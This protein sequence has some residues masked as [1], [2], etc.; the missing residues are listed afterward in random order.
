M[1][2]SFNFENYRKALAK[3]L[4]DERKNVSPESTQDKLEEKKGL[5]KYKISELL[6]KA[7]KKMVLDEVLTKHKYTEK[8]EKN[9]LSL[10]IEEIDISNQI[11]EVIKLSIDLDRI[12]A[13]NGETYSSKK[14]TAEL[15]DEII[16]LVEEELKN[17][18]VESGNI[19]RLKTEFVN[20]I[21]GGALLDGN[22]I[23]TIID[24]WGRSMQYE[25]R[26]DKN[27]Y[28]IGERLLADTKYDLPF[29]PNQYITT[30]PDIP[31]NFDRQDM[32][33][34]QELWFSSPSSK[35]ESINNYF[36]KTNKMVIVNKNSKRF[37]EYLFF[38]PKIP[39]YS[40]STL[41]GENNPTFEKIIEK[42]EEWL[43]KGLI[44][45]SDGIIL[46]ISDQASWADIA[47]WIIN[48]SSGKA[49]KIKGLR[50]DLKTGQEK[51]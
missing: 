21:T 29:N 31:E 13:I 8:N 18:G 32:D 11:P 28:G 19:G 38:S 48:L 27:L 41:T 47:D 12:D 43:K 35:P 44:H 42:Y 51:S 17:F 46:N 30:A 1:K 5:V 2:T 50:D 10:D 34:Y 33:H 24:A 6:N 9:N 7:N 22:H 23:N 3:E 36:S 45:H 37:L 4:I 26:L 40:H 14:Q 25:P 20:K 39:R 49:Y 16:P 15:H